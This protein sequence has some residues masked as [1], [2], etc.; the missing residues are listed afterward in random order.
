MRSLNGR[1]LKEAWTQQWRASQELPERQVAGRRLPEGRLGVLPHAGP[2]RGV[3][4]VADGDVAT[5]ILFDSTEVV[6]ERGVVLS[7]WRNGLG[8]GE[9]LRD[10]QFPVIFRGSRYAER[11]PIGLKEVVETATPEKL[12]A[13][14]QKHYVAP[15]MT[16][17]IVGDLHDGWREFVERSWV[18]AMVISF[19]SPISVNGVS[20]VLFN[21]IRPVPLMFARAAAKPVSWN[22]GLPDTPSPL[23][24][25]TP[26]PLVLSVRAEIV[27]GALLT[28]TPVEADSKEADVPF[29]AIV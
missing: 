15:R 19:A 24:T 12:R 6:A 22:V 18:V 25:D 14:W 16:L 23:V 27:L 3:A 29:R 9:R 26:L 13:F 1:N 8:A 2:G 4:G 28:I 20:V 17:V 7:E 21:P 11:L 5:G 10:K